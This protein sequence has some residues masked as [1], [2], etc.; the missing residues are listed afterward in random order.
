[1]AK[2]MA[3]VAEKA[4]LDKDKTEAVLTALK[5]VL[6]EHLATQPNKKIHVAGLFSA[7][8][9]QKPRKEARIKMVFGKSMK[10]PPREPCTVV[11]LVPGRKL[12][13]KK[14]KGV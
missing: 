8:A 12:C 1:M 2:L 4:K 3:R 6:Q 5:M 7:V 14:A 9:F 10:L 13:A 11:K